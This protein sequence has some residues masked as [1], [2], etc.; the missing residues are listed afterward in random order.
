[1][2]ERLVTTESGIKRRGGG[3]NRKKII[4]II[5]MLKEKKGMCGGRQ[6]WH[7]NCLAYSTSFHSFIS[8]L[9]YPYILLF[10]FPAHGR[11]QQGCV[12]KEI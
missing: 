8:F 6:K 11:D 9:F 10:L 4:K 5:K 1:M 3:S 2:I 7:G 12:W